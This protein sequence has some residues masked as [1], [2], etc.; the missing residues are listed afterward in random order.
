VEPAPKDVSVTVL[1]ETSAEGWGET[2]LADLETRVAKD[3]K[4]VAGPVPLAVA[5]ESATEK[6]ARLVV[7]GDADFAS[8]G[9]IANAANLYLLSS[10]V[11]WLLERE[12]LISIPPKSTDQVSVSLSRGDVGRITL[13]VLLVL[14]IAAIALGLAVWLRRRR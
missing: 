12:S 8:S 7:V 10:A 14:P 11:N 13:L 4:D 6:K 9:G 3:E 2:N 1:A 5:A